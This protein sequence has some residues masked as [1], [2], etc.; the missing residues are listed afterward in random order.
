MSR[1]RAPRRQ[2][3]VVVGEE[4]W[5]RRRAVA[6]LVSAYLTPA[7]QELNLDQLDAAEVDVAEILTRADTLPFFGGTRV[8]VVRQADRLPAPAQ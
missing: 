2:V 5:L 1:E 3:Y 6:R 4:A 8:V 7:E